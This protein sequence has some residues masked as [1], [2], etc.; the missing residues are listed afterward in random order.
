MRSKRTLPQVRLTRS[1]VRP[2]NPALALPFKT[3][4]S[5]KQRPTDHSKSGKPS[6]F[7]E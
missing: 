5:L 2:N 1:C 7:S 6:R 3:N 4:V